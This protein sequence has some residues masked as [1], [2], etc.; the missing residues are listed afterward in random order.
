MS[1]SLSAIS[2]PTFAFKRVHGRKVPVL[3]RV[4][5]V[6]LGKHH[7]GQVRI[8]WNLKVNGHRLGRG[9]YLITLRGF[10]SHHNLLGTTKPV[11]FTVHH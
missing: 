9:R 6:P 11:I 10:D 8:H 1:I 3:K 5:R 2:S 7:R 4:G